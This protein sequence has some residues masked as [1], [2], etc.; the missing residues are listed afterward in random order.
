MVNTDTHPARFCDANSGFRSERLKFRSERL[1]FDSERSNFRSEQWKFGSERW[2]L[3]NALSEFE[4]ARLNEYGIEAA[5][6]FV[7][8]YTPATRLSE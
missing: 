4:C 1:K 3:E 5:H 2:N 8:G 6:R 7:M